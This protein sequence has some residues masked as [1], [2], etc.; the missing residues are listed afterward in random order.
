MNVECVTPFTRGAQGPFRGTHARISRRPSSVRDERRRQRPAVDGG[1]GGD[2][3][4]WDGGRKKNSRYAAHLRG[5][6]RGTD[7]ESVAIVARAPGGPTHNEIIN[8]QSRAAR[9]LFL[10]RARDR[11]WSSPRCHRVARSFCLDSEA[12]NRQPSA[13]L[14]RSAYA[15]LLNACSTRFQHPTW[16]PSCR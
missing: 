12:R 10:T 1:R 7:D 16:R 4:R 14:L 9:R 13:F 11:A 3:G 6:E 15:A 8:Y 5:G 2:R